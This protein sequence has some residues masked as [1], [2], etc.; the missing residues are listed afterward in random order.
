MA[1]ATA[2]TAKAQTTF[3]NSCMPAPVCYL[4]LS[5]PLLAAD[6]TTSRALQNLDRHLPHIGWVND[7]NANYCKQEYEV[8]S[9]FN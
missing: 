9:S 2:S 1:R 4:S 8:A 5:N 3:Y 6:K 7:A